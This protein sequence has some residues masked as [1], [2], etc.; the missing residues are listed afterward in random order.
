MNGICAD[1]GKTIP[2]LT[3]CWLIHLTKQPG[4]KIGLTKTVC[5]ECHDE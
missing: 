1:C 5:T 3:V 2:K 4:A